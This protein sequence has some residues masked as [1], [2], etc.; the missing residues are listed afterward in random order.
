MLIYQWTMPLNKITGFFEYRREVRTGSTGDLST[1]APF[2]LRRPLQRGGWGLVF[3]TQVRRR[4][5]LLRNLSHPG[6]RSFSV[7][8]VD[9]LSGPPPHLVGPVVVSRVE[10]ADANELDGVT[11]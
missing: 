1:S 3:E 2:R 9:G 8:H 10:I 6:G 4:P 11:A 5:G 7:E